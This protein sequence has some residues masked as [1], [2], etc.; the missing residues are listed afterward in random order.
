MGS[1]LGST[2]SLHEEHWETRDHYQEA[3]EVRSERAADGLPTD[4]TDL[5]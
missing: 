4:A 1:L 3:E 5:Y 2:L